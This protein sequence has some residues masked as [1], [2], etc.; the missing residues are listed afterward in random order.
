MSTVAIM[1]E[2][3]TNTKLRELSPT[4]KADEMMKVL[5]TRS[6]KSSTYMMRME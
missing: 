1:K 5:T 4:M 6:I 2:M 3:D